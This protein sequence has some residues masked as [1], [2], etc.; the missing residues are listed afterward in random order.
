MKTQV[1]Q[2]RIEVL[3]LG[4]WVVSSRG[5]SAVEADAV[6]RAKNGDPAVRVMPETERSR[7]VVK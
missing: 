2:Y 1:S 4:R 3:V 7:R 6:K 5:V